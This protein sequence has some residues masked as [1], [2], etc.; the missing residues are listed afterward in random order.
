MNAFEIRG[1]G[2]SKLDLLFFF[3]RF[4]NLEF[5]SRDFRLDYKKKSGRRMMDAR[6]LNMFCYIFAGFRVLSLLF[7]L[8][9]QMNIALISS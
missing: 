9:F 5:D 4:G 3:H 6:V 8:L 1:E 2:R 7:V